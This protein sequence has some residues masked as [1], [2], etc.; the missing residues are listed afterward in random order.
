MKVILVCIF[1]QD[2]NE[3][4]KTMIQYFQTVYTIYQT[5]QGIYSSKLGQ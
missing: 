5:R 3:K 4:H 1:K 2:L